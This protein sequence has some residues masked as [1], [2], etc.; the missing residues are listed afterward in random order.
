MKEAEVYA[1]LAGIFGECFDDATIV[2]WPET[3]A[4]DIAG[5]DSAKEASIIYRA[6]SAGLGLI[7]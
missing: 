3:S 5:W 6:V 7:V 2:L 4:R 1:A